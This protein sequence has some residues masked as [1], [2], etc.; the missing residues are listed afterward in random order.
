MDPFWEPGVG[1]TD[2]GMIAAVVIALV[3][4]GGWISNI[5]TNAKCKCGHSATSHS[6]SALGPCRWVVV[7]EGECD[8]REFER[9]N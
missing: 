3:V 2:L 4:I 8:C 9:S 5:Y 1:V 7:T 6:P